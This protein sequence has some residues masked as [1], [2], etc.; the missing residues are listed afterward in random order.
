MNQ[1][2]ALLCSALLLASCKKEARPPSLGDAVAVEQ[3]GG[4]ATQLIA[5]GSEIPTSATESFTT[6]TDDEKRIALHV[7]RG[8]GRSA[9]GLRSDGWWMV[10]GVSSGKAGEPRVLVTFDVD[11]QGALSVSARE[12]DR[13][14]KVTKVDDDTRAKLSPSPLSE[15]DDGEDDD[16]PE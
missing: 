6:A 10:D 13:K 5:R 9:A 8:S 4:T 7:L 2:G 1:R 11:A 3:P 12:E 15:P 16:D 14:L